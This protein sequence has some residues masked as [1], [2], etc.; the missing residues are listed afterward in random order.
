MQGPNQEHCGLS[1]R[2]KTLGPSVCVRLQGRGLG[3]GD[4]VRKLGQGGDA[5]WLE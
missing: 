3:A 4:S 5:V 2:K 1:L